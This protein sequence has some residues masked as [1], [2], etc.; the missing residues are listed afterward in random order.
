VEDLV[1]FLKARLDRDE[2]V[3]RAAMGA[4]WKVT[5]GGTIRVDT[6][7][8]DAAR[9]ERRALVATAEN[10]AYAEHIARL[11]PSRVLRQVTAQRRLIALY[12]KERWTRQRG[13]P[14]GGVLEE[15]L[16]GLAAQYSDHPAY[17][18]EWA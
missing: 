18:P 17:R 12:E 7:A 15:V 8:E 6:S 1:T 4:S 10:E 16:R 9:Q 5:A 2:A 14:A 13:V 3:A 11:S